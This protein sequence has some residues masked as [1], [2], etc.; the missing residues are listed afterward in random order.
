MRV[1]VAAEKTDRRGYRRLQ[2]A[3]GGSLKI[4]ER[5]QAAFVTDSADGENRIVLQRPLDLGHLGN[6]LERIRRAVVPQ[7]LDHHRPEQILAAHHEL[8]HEGANLG[9]R[10]RGRGRRRLHRM[11]RQRTRQRRAHELGLLSIDSGQQPADRHGIG[12][13][14][15]PRVR[16]GAEP[17]VLV[18]Q[19]LH[20]RLRGSR[21]VEAG[22]QHE[23]AEADVTSPRRRS[24]PCRAA[25]EPRL[26]ARPAGPFARL[27][28]HGKVERA[29]QVDGGL[30][31]RGRNLAGGCG[32]RR[33]G[34]WRLRVSRRA[35]SD[36]EQ[37]DERGDD[38]DSQRH[39]Q[40]QSTA[41]SASWR[42]AFSSCGKETG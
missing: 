17:V 19:H 22:E 14:L 5:D 38:R 28:P 24:T 26:P 34:F 31:L 6:G 1:A 21:I 25:P 29:Q 30:Q 33:R 35:R 16:H 39:R 3:I 40:I 9:R 18:V 4:R 10:I 13:M 37:C 2:I 27:H 42:Y 12:V 36:G 41:L 20:H 32:W 23:G 11:R 7:R 8:G 15:E